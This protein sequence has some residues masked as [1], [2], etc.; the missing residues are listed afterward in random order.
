MFF[1]NFVIFVV[2][3]SYSSTFSPAF[4]SLTNISPSVVTKISA[5]FA[6]RETFGRGSM[7]RFG[8]GGTLYGWIDWDGND[9]FDDD[10]RLNFIDNVTGEVLG[11]AADLGHNPDGPKA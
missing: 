6:A 8:V 2:Q 11:F 10:E 5:D 7:S 4:Q 3:P 1:V 9:R